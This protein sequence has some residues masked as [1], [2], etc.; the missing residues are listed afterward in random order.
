MLSVSRAH[1]M[2]QDETISA[3][4][5]ATAKRRRSLASGEPDLHIALHFTLDVIENSDGSAVPS[6]HD[7][8]SYMH[9][10]Y[11]THVDEH[12]ARQHSIDPTVR[13]PG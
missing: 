12:A 11:E 6:V 8:C 10:Q 1:S 9:T 3:Q 4:F 7:R 13:Y 5:A 2:T